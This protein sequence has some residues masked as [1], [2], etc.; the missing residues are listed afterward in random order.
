MKLSRSHGAW[1]PMM[2]RLMTEA[3]QDRCEV[4]DLPL[5]WVYRRLFAAGFTPTDLIDL[6][7][8]LSPVVRKRAGLEALMGDLNSDLFNDLRRRQ[9]IFPFGNCD[10]PSTVVRYMR[11][12][13]DMIE[14]ELA[15]TVSVEEPA[16]EL[17]EV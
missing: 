9:K 1:T 14:E 10:D 8:L 3:E 17:V 2:I 13:A 6:E 7:S 5:A 15:A 11:V 16:G 12:W 4:T